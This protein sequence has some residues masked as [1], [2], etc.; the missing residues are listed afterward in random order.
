[1]V[2]KKEIPMIAKKKQY[3]IFIGSLGIAVEGYTREG[4]LRAP[5]AKHPH[6]FHRS[7][8]FPKTLFV[9]LMIGLILGL[10]ACNKP[11]NART[12]SQADASPQEVKPPANP[13]SGA[14]PEDQTAASPPEPDLIDAATFIAHTTIPTGT[15]LGQG[16]VFTKTWELENSGTTTW[17]LDYFL[18]FDTGEQMHGPDEQPIFEYVRPLDG[19]VSFRYRIGSPLRAWKREVPSFR[20]LVIR[21]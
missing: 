19:G 9:F 11:T 2:E 10:G 6:S 20:P 7:R 3:G 8:R 17:T 1:V 13:D 14:P 4:V 15:V 18:V 5:H 16:Q 21:G 12:D